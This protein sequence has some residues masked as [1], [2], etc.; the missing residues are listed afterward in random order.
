MMEHKSTVEPVF[1]KDTDMPAGITPLTVIR[2]VTEVISPQNLDGV[3]KFMR[4]W[5]IYFKTLQSREGFLGHETML[6]GEKAVP[7][8]DQCPE[9]YKLTI[10]GLPLSVQNKEVK[11]CLLSKRHQ[12][13][14]KN[15][16]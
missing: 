8:H 16:V 7:L 1:L 10:K 4:L 6:I 9:T 13:R 11:S 14:I 3:Q 2:A 15:N 5:R 12:A